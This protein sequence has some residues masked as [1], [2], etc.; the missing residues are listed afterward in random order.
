MSKK[1][2]TDID[3]NL[4]NEPTPQI[5]SKLGEKYANLAQHY[6]GLNMIFEFHLFKEVAKEF[7]QMAGKLRGGERLK[8]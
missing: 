4:Y 3:L 2:K 1:K 6:R 5:P 7:N 8:G